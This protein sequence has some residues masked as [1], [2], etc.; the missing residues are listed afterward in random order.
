MDFTFKR[1]KIFKD[2]EF[3]VEKSIF[4]IRNNIG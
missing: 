2:F 1:Y 3:Y 4:M